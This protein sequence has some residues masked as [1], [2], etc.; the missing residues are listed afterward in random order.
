[1]NEANKAAL[2]LCLIM[3]GA[4]ASIMLIGVFG[5]YIINNDLSWCKCK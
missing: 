1:M 2:I 3:I 4:V 5:D